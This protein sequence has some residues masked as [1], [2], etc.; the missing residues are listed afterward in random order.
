MEADKIEA[1]TI[2]MTDVSFTRYNGSSFTRGDVSDSSDVLSLSN[3]L[4][5]TWQ[6]GDGTE[7][8]FKTDAGLII[9]SPLVEPDQYGYLIRS[10]ALLT[11]GPLVD[12]TK[13][14]LREYTFNKIGSNLSLSSKDGVNYTLTK[15]E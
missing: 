14:V 1:G 10:G 3:D 15:V 8:E 12:G 5:G 9:T 6:M 2:T 4:V 7:Y 13:A 11:L